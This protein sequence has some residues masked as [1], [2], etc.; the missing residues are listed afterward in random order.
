ML[1][2]FVKDFFAPVI[3]S[4]YQEGGQFKLYVVSD[5]M[6]VIVMAWAS[7]F[8]QHLHCCTHTL[9][10]SPIQLLC[11]W[12]QRRICVLNN[13]R[14]MSITCTLVMVNR[15]LFA[16]FNYEPLELS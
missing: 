6:K 3:A 8:V 13:M 1:H 10:F 5:L 12:K 7:S 15:F 4:S 14:A 16:N 2:Y 9:S 11:I